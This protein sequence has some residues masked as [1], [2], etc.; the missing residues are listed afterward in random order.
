[1]KELKVLGFIMI[2]VSSFG[3]GMYAQKLHNEVQQPKPPKVETIEFDFVNNGNICWIDPK[4]KEQFSQTLPL[5][6][7]RIFWDVPSERKEYATITDKNGWYPSVELHYHEKDLKRL[8][9]E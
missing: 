5:F 8:R 2:M 6:N 4:T 9:G 3:L 7:R 1:M